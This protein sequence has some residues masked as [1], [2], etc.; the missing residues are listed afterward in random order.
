[1][2]MDTFLRV[3]ASECSNGSSGSNR[4]G[5]RDQS[6]EPDATSPRFSVQRRFK[7]RQRLP[8]RK[9]RMSAGGKRNCFPAAN[10]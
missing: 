7:Y 2:R 5:I 9:L 1:M 4:A 10:E 6:L 8:V 3:I